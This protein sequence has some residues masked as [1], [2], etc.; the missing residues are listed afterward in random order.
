M[1]I[2]INMK[3]TKTVKHATLYLMGVG[4]VIC[5]FMTMFIATIAVMAGKL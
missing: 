3:E 4:L 2:D 1:I 5:L